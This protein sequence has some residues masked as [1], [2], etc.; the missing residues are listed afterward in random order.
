MRYLEGDGRV[1]LNRSKE[2]YDLILVD[3][4][5]GGYVPFHLLTREF[6]ALVKQRL[7]P[8]GA[9]AFN[10]H[11]GTKLYA[12]TLL[13]LRSVFPGAAPLSVRRRRDDHRGDGATPRPT[14]QRS[15]S[16]ASAL[17]EKFGFRFRACRSCSRAAPTTY[18]RSQTGRAA[19]RRFRAGGP[20]RHDRRERVPGEAAEMGGTTPSP[21][22]CADRPRWRRDRP[23]SC[24]CRTR[25]PSAASAACR[26]CD[27][28][29]DRALDLGIA[30]CADALFLV[31][32]DV[33]RHR[34]PQGPLNSSPPCRGALELAPARSPSACGT[35]CSARWSRG[36]IPSSP[37]RP[38]RLR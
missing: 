15:R 38:C 33:A 22:R 2:P 9:A 4:F 36:R 21:A 3:A 31:R 24:S 32:G 13:T 11:D 35:P 25:S 26:P 5:H 1:F 12:S 34:T 8:G 16:R 17:Q 10:V 30:P 27:A 28:L 18:R 6:Y 37:C 23:R 19:H 20:L 29:G 7:A 14:R